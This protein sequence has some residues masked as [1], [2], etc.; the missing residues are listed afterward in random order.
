MPVL[1]GIEVGVSDDTSEVGHGVP[2]FSE[3][4]LLTTDSPKTHVGGWPAPVDV[5]CETVDDGR[6]WAVHVRVVVEVTV[7]AGEWN[8]DDGGGVDDE[9][10]GVA[11]GEDEDEE[12][13]G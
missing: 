5:G 9:G 6:V 1:G 11:G 12:E 7:V 8:A 4:T 2:L 13:D 10:D 3:G